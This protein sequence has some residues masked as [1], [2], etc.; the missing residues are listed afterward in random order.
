MQSVAVGNGVKILRENLKFKRAAHKAPRPIK[1][2]A[3]LVPEIWSLFI[4]ARAINDNNVRPLNKR[5]NR[6]AKQLAEEQRFKL[7]KQKSDK[8]E[9]SVNY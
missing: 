5:L 2:A 4:T 7:K 9:T 6:E 8:K 1:A 3:V